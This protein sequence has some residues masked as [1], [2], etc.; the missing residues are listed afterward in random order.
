MDPHIEDLFEKAPPFSDGELILRPDFERDC[1]IANTLE[2][3]L[4]ESFGG[5]VSR[6]MT[7]YSAARLQT[8]RLEQLHYFRQGYLAAK[9][10]LKEQKKS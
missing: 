10:E 1:S 7:E 5:E 6:L 4:M 3:L 2:D 9:K 8:E